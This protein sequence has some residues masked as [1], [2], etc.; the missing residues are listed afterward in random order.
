L[1]ARRVNRRGVGMD[2]NLAL[3]PERLFI[4]PPGEVGV[5]SLIATVTE[6]LYFGDHVR[7][8]M[9]AAGHSGIMARMLQSASA[10]VP[11]PGDR[12]PVWFRAEDCRAL[13]PLAQGGGEA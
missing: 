11:K 7:V 8:V 4:G 10:P 2:T 1:S 6:T 13:N 12:L 3:R 9:E 5:N